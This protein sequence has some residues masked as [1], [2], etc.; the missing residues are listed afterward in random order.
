MSGGLLLCLPVRSTKK[1]ITK[2][3]TFQPTIAET[4][5][6]S[7][8]ASEVLF[9][10]LWGRLIELR[11]ITTARNLSGKTCHKTVFKA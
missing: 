11:N 7:V 8:E 5:P 2:N 10:S 3:K 4:L 1:A 6:S 9:F